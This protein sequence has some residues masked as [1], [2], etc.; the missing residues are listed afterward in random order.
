MFAGH[1]RMQARLGLG[2]DNLLVVCGTAQHLLAHSK[3]PSTHVLL[4]RLLSAQAAHS[5]AIESRVG[6]VTQTLPQRGFA[7]APFLLR[8]EAGLPSPCCS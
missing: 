5:G 7:S 4:G 3:R 6:S 2:T 1:T 8:V